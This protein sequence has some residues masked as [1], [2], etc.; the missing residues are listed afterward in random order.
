M[1]FENSLAGSLGVR[2]QGMLVLEAGCCDF[3]VAVHCG[4]SLKA[5]QSEVC[6]LSCVNIKDEGGFLVHNS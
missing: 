5:F 4:L 2:Y 6:C 3:Q 1:E